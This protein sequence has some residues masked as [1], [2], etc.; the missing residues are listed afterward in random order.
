METILVLRAL[1]VLAGV[2]WAGA[3]FVTVLFL[4]K[5]V[6]DAGPA[7][8]QVMGA[9]AKRRYFDFVPAVAILSVL[10]GIE[11]MRRVSTNFDGAWMGSPQGVALS[12]GGLAALLALAVGLAIGRPNTLAAIRSM[13][14]AAQMTDGAEKAA[15]AAKAA[16]ARSRGLAALKAAAVLVLVSL[17]TMAVARYL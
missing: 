15:L 16:S 13:A 2:L 8:G 10:S 5:A 3:L 12:I 9:L 14:A 1:H 4:V 11:L 6:A 17:V 7:G